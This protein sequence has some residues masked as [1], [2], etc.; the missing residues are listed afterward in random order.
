M[1]D[2]VI[3]LIDDHTN[4]LLNTVFTYSTLIIGYDDSAKNYSRR[5][6]LFL[7]SC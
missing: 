1:F 2:V 4:L 7:R 3:L 6:G 5:H